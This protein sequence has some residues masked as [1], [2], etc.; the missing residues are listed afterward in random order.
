[1]EREKGLRDKQKQTQHHFAPSLGSQL[2]KDI[3]SPNG[4]G[5][6]E[7]DRKREREKEK[8]REMNRGRELC[9][10]LTLSANFFSLEETS[11]GYAFKKGRSH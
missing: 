7:R 5:Q 11:V 9:N 6:R 8:E 2:L 3:F 4:K 10:Q 1:M